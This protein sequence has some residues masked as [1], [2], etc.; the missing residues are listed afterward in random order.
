M[1]QCRLKSSSADQGINISSRL[2]VV[3]HMHVSNTLSTLYHGQP[4][5][6]PADIHMLYKI[7]II[8]IRGFKK[9]KK[10]KKKKRSDKESEV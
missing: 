6:F 8:K 3:L 9:D 5:N 4:L 1:Y 7:K 10:Y 2:P